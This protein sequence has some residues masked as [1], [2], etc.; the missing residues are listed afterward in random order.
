M[1][2]LGHSM[3]GLLS[4]E[5]VLLADEGRDTPK[6]HRIVGTINFDTPFLGM[7]PGVVVSGLGSLFR[8]APASPGA[9][10]KDLLDGT[11]KQHLGPISDSGTFS[12]RANLADLSPINSL[13]ALPPQ[14]PNYN[15]PFSN[16][17]RIPVRKGWD[18]ALHFVT[19]HSDGLTRATKSYVTS[20]AEFGGCMADY[21][22]LKR[23]YSAIRKLEDSAGRD[24]QPNVRFVNYYTAS[25]GRP[26]KTYRSTTKRTQPG[27]GEQMQDLNISA[28]QSRSPSRS[29]R[30]SIEERKDGCWVPA[31]DVES[32]SHLNRLA[33]EASYFGSDNDLDKLTTES[34][35]SLDHAAGTQPD[36]NLDSD[37]S[38]SMDTLPSV[39]S[40]LPLAEQ[41]PRAMSSES[42]SAGL[43]I[44]LSTP[45]SK[46]KQS[47]PP[48]PPRSKLPPE[49]P[50]FDASLYS[51][52]NVRREAEKEHSRTVKDYRQTVKEHN[53][54]VKQ[55][56]Q[57]ARKY[58]KGAEKTQQREIKAQAKVEAKKAREAAKQS[59]PPSTT[60]EE[61]T[62]EAEEQN[63]PAQSKR[64]RKFCMLPSK[65]SDGS[66]DPCWVRVYM[67]GVDEVGAHCGLFFIGEHYE[68]LVSDVAGRVENWVQDS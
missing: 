46:A 60:A 50:P 26:K 45:V 43:P 40:N 53:K 1:I 3:G 21:K 10:R 28:P 68:W 56:Q 5:M 66:R 39:E 9:E 15:P 52:K 33:T 49:P 35:T 25:T 44:P 65:S 30:M 51:D 16:D 38:K 31:S 61:P 20:H 58:K 42:S 54:A 18:N 13:D 32:D 36:R 23:R 37:Y 17:N 8:P 22:G 59:G 41:S 19:K 67:H 7:H 48:L 12:P 27:D 34:I 14:D 11:S 63:I 6:R 57:L 55:H 47:G 62:S 29:P 24:G 4:A 64:D 2:L